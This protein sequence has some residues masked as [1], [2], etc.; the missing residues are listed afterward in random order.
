[1][2]TA[3][4]FFIDGDQAVKLPEE[5]EFSGED[6]LIRKHGNAVILVPN[7]KA[8]ETFMRG[9]NSFSNDFMEDSKK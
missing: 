8:W 7:D 1:M 3:K 6:V 9:L 4:L 2:Q 5:Y